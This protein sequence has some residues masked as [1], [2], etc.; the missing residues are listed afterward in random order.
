MD[1]V[2]EAM[3]LALKERWDTASP[4]VAPGPAAS[5][6]KSGTKRAHAAADPGD[7]RFMPLRPAPPPPRVHKPGLARIRTEKT[8]PE[9]LARNR[10]VAAIRDSRER[11]S[12][13]LLQGAV[14][15]K[16]DELGQHVLG[17]TGP[18]RARGK[19]LTAANLAAS[20]VLDG[21]RPVVLVDLDLRAPSIARLFGVDVKP[22][23][24]ECLFNGAAPED[25]L[26]SPSIEGLAVLPSRRG[27]RGVRQ[28][29]CSQNLKALIGRIRASWPDAVVVLDLPP[30]AGGID[31]GLI[32]DLADAV[33]LVVEDGVTR[34]AD[35]RR[36]F[37]ALGRHTVVGTVLN[38]A[39][40]AG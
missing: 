21:Q 17:V 8:A 40:R 4:P 19:T 39:A 37:S 15:R 12:Y 35:Y 22:G 10:L 29:L 26:F 18:R 23:L 24:E 36:V 3:E 6:A 1:K 14:A 13:C 34:E 2:R 30:I 31:A 28:V 38:K 32:A 16:L 9:T 25:A 20:L 7:V 27:S 11:E 33:L 5:N